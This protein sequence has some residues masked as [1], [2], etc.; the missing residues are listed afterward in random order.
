M[1]LFIDDNRVYISYLSNYLEL[2]N[3]QLKS[4][5]SYENCIEY[6]NNN[7]E[8]FKQIKV[9]ICDLFI[10]SSF[11]NNNG[12]ELLREIKKIVDLPNKTILFSR[13][14]RSLTKI[15]KDFIHDNE[16]I[17]IEKFDNEKLLELLNGM[18]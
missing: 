11:I 18:S 7:I 13:N 1:I 17:V 15:D 14:I 6:I 12:M 10:N 4:F 8:E 16:I 5:Y 3:I 9:L 2:D